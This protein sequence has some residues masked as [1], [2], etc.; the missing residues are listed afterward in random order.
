MKDW[1][2]LYQGWHEN[3]VSKIQNVTFTLFAYLLQW[4]VIFI[5]LI[6]LYKTLVFIYIVY[7]LFGDNYKGFF[8]RLNFIDPI[9]MLGLWPLSRIIE[10][11]IRIV[12]LISAY[13]VIVR[14]IHVSRKVTWEYGPRLVAL[15]SSVLICF[16][17]FAPFGL[18]ENKL[19]HKILENKIH[20]SKQIQD[21][22]EKYEKPKDNS[23]IY[24]ILKLQ[25]LQ[26][27]LK[28]S[29]EQSM[30]PINPSK[31]YFYIILFILQIRLIIKPPDSWVDLV[32]S[33]LGQDTKN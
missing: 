14:F 33:L 23:K 24:D 11:Y 25:S 2:V 6:F 28:L 3:K 4:L 12:L 30:L 9:G 10:I 20:I 17:L 7:N 26:N 16:L 5:G 32:T 1:T 27:D 21:F 13:L 18:F 22:S 19:E 31:A 8:I 15:G 29:A